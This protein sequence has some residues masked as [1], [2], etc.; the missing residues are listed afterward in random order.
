M[1]NWPVVDGN[2]ELRKTGNTSAS[3]VELK[4]PRF[5]HKPAGGV[6][7]H[8]KQRIPKG[9]KTSKAS[10]LSND[11][12][13]AQKLFR[14]LKSQVQALG[15]QTF[16]GWDKK[17]WV[18]TQKKAIGM[19]DEKQ[20]KVPFHIMKGIRKKQTLKMKKYEAEARLQDVVTGKTL[21]KK[22]GGRHDIKGK[23]YQRVY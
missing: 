1:Q 8:V 13:D 9:S 22:K 10:P 17:E 21:K 5:E 18:T 19:K 7:R 15:A 23:K 2:G 4:V 12:F 3:R 6:S 16:R 20:Q 11:P 14:I